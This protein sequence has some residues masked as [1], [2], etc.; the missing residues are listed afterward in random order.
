MYPASSSTVDAL[1]IAD[2][3]GHILERL[4][5]S[6]MKHSA[7]ARHDVAT[8]AGVDNYELSRLGRRAEVVFWVDQLRFKVCGRNICQPQV[9]ML[10]HVTLGTEEQTYIASSSADVLVASCRQ[11]QRAIE[12]ATR[13]PVH[14]VP[15][16]VNTDVFHP[17]SRRDALRAAQGISP[18]DFVLG[19]VGKASADHLGRKGLRLFG[20]VVDAAHSRWTDV[21]VALV[22]PGWDVLATE[23]RT[24]GVKVVRSE[25]NSCDE[26]ASAYP[27][28]DALIVTA[29]E[30][31]GPCTV[32]EGMAAGVPVIS[33][34][35]GLVPDLIIDGTTGF[36]CKNRKVPEYLDALDV[37]RSNPERRL[38]IQ[39]EARRLVHT[40]HRDEVVIPKID[41]RAL[42]KAASENYRARAQRE[43][44]GR[45]L[46]QGYVLARH[47]TRKASGAMRAFHETLEKAAL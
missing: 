35:V 15:Y 45:F 38:A 46:R 1:L 30:E 42:Y 31:G 10:H 33:S 47:L 28:L 4:S 43:I 36:I 22:G 3:Q 26:T 7:S 12:T 6:W 17:S 32:L 41:F 14:V 21:A 9:L 5:L 13:R 19:F 25:F 18:T 44:A 8:S 40:E 2:H 24:R 16:S 29:R 23:L 39:Y 37:L 27:T 11:W 20:E 34:A